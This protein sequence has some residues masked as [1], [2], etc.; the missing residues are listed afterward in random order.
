MALQNFW[1]FC[2]ANLAVLLLVFLPQPSAAQAP[3]DRIPAPHLGYGLHLDPNVP[4]DPAMVD[5]LGMDWVKLYADAQIP[6]FPN[7]RILFRQDMNYPDDWNAFRAWLTDRARFLN[8]QGVEA[9]EIHNE[10]NLSLEWRDQVPNAAQYTEMLRVAYQTIKAVAP[11]MIVVSGGLAPTETTPDRMAISDLEYAREMLRLGAGNWFDAFGYHPYGYNAPPEQEPAMGRLNFRR[12]ELI[13]DLL[14]EFGITDKQIWLTEFGWLRDPAEDG[15]AC[16]DQDPDFQG[17]AWL[18]VDGATQADYIARAFRYAD[19]NWP[20]AGPTFLWNLNFSMRPNDGSLAM[21]SHQRWFGLLRQDGTPTLAFQRVATMPKRYSDYLPT[22]ILYADDMTVET[23]AFC[24][25]QVQVGQF[26]VGNTGY[27]GNFTARVEPA[28]A[29]NGPP[30][31][32]STTSARVGT[33]VDVFVDATGLSP[34]LHVVYVNVRA[35]IGGQLRA[36]NVRGFV[37]V[38]ESNDRDC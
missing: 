3:P 24:P 7:K 19:R 33:D 36:Q 18:R 10:P 8:A 4:V 11:N 20:W 27:P 13:W 25:G 34:G 5:Q 28:T 14:L 31:N 15:V 30:V 21:C 37:I 1:K 17:F 12:T 26:N 6:Q 32:V 23:S 16:S 35:T 9:I 22:M 38:R 29:P 2:L